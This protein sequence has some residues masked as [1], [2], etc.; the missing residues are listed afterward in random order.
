M[1]RVDVIDFLYAVCCAYLG[2]V[3]AIDCVW[4]SLGGG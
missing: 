1:I 3:G 2:E 4:V